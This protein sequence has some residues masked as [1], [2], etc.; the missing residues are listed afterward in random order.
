MK[1]I[2]LFLT[3]CLLSVSASADM[4]FDLGF[5]YS[6]DTLHKSGDNSNTQTFYNVDVLFNIDSRKS[7]NVGWSVFG[8][9][10]S[11]TQSATNT[12][13]SSMDMGPTLRWN[14]DRSGMFSTTLAYGYLARGAYGTTGASSEKWEGT[15]YLAQIAAQIPV[16]EKF[17]I[18]LS[19]NY[20]GA[21]Y[22]T[23]IVSNVESSNDARKTWVFPMMSLTWKP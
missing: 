2:L 21:N 12:S 10:Q 9:S 17:Y 23:K 22:S 6:G 16:L 8:I 20:Y 1:R 7:W 19:L 3:C 4:M 18:G 11:T 13:Y 5:A 15:S 14:I